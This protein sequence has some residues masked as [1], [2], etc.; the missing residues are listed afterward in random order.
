MTA[1]SAAGL[2]VAVLVS[3]SGTNLQALIDARVPIVHVLS[4]RKA[5][6]G[7]QRAAK[8]GIS[9]DIFSLVTYLKNNPGKTRVDYDAEL[10]ERVLSCTP[11]LVVLAG[12]MHILSETFLAPFREQNVRII[13]LHPALP[14]AFDGANAIQR[15]WDAFQRKEIEETG[16]MVHEVVQEV[17]RGTPIMVQE[18]PCINGESL[19]DLEERI[20]K[21][22]HQLIVKATQKVLQEISAAKAAS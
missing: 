20:H 1:E 12:F 7:L 2:R 21:V 3:G 22:E 9:T 15:A 19:S 5:A 6:Y 11:H 14:G 16:V 4:N 18:V 10:A 17:D 8:A 13:N